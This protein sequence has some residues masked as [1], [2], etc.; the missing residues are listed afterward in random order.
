[1]NNIAIFFDLE[2]SGLSLECC[3]IL[4]I[5]WLRCDLDNKKL[6]DSQ[7]FLIKPLTDNYDIDAKVSQITGINS[8]MLKDYGSQKDLVFSMFEK[9]IKENKYVIGHN[10]REFDV[11]I[12]NRY[13]FNKISP[14][15]IIDTVTDIPYPEDL[16]TRKLT[17]L[18]YEHGIM[19]RPAHRAIVD[20]LMTMNLF[21][22]YNLKD[23]L[24]FRDS[25]FIE[26]KAHVPPP[27]EAGHE[28]YKKLAYDFG[29]RYRKEKRQ[30]TRVLRE[31]EFKRI[32]PS[33]LLDYEVL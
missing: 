30:F 33:L 17:Y 12:I 31:V 14:D 8:D 19:F 25:P 3:D 18:S 11:P 22:Q 7:S 10:I 27:W 24:M 16:K 6:L 28:E 1:M 15:K 23:I 29:F 13:I 21:F 2:T 5:A 20:C 9:E 32:K 4:E 26:L